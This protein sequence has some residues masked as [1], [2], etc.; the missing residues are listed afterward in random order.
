MTHDPEAAWPLTQP[1]QGYYPGPAAGPLFTPGNM[2]PMGAPMYRHRVPA[3]PSKTPPWGIRIAFLAI[4]LATA[5]PLTAI[6]IT[7]VG[8]I[9]LIV[10]WAG[11]VMVAGLAFGVN[12]PK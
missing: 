3:A 7:M 2:A 1:D 8:L 4:I 11:I 5:I 12:R 6:A 9:G 10:V